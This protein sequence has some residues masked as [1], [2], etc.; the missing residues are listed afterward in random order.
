LGGKEN[1]KKKKTLVLLEA[2]RGQ[3]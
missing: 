2:S 1:T 3:V